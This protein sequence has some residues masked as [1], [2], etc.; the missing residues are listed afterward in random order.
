MLQSRCRSSKDRTGLL[1]K[2]MPRSWKPSRV[3]LSLTQRGEKVQIEVPFQSDGSIYHE[4]LDAQFG[5][6]KH[7]LWSKLEG[8]ADAESERPDP[9]TVRG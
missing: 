1:M 7:D 5:R 2:A 6:A 3:T 8:P 9:E 4:M